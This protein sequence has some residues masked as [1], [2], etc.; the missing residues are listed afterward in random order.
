MTFNYMQRTISSEFNKKLL[1]F[2]LGR[3]GKVPAGINAKRNVLPSWKE[4]IRKRF[5]AQVK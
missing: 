4:L 1:P 5:K 3:E 2:R